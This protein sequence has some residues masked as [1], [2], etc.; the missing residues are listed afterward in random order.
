M[1]PCLH[2]DR[3]KFLPRISSLQMDP[4]N[5][6]VCVLFHSNSLPPS[7]PRLHLLPQ[8]LTKNSITGPNNA[9]NPSFTL[10]LPRQPCHSLTC[11]FLFFTASSVCLV[12]GDF[13]SSPTGS[14]TH[15]VFAVTVWLEYLSV[16][17]AGGF[18]NHLSLPS[19]WNQLFGR[20]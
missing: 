1:L 17:A 16:H 8:S 18:S 13:P 6:L 4:S 20:F 7:E 10:I 3:R 15:S 11:L 9:L 12:T 14:T 5:I 2:V 19:G